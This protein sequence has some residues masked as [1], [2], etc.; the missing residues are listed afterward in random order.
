MFIAPIS[1]TDDG[2]KEA[3]KKVV[4]L[5]AVLQKQNSKQKID[6][7]SFGMSADWKLA[8]QSGSNCIRVGSAIFGER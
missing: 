8:L 1:L 3:F 6:I 7:L 2:L 4:R 5:N